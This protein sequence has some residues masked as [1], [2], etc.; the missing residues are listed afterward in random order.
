M[1]FDGCLKKCTPISLPPA[2]QE[3]LPDCQTKE[4]LQCAQK[5][6]VNLWMSLKLE[7]CPRPC[8]VLQYNEKGVTYQSTDDHSISFAF[9]FMWHDHLIVHEEYLIY[10]LVGMV[11][12]VGGTL[13]MF[14]GFSF[15]NV[16]SHILSIVKQYFPI[17]LCK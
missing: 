13:G 5:V 6:E 1:T 10:D 14:I 12:S 7:D 3:V 17:S 9:Q 15:S 4:E 11:G 16:I 2:F 8:S